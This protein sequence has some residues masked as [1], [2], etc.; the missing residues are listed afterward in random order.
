MS[1]RNFLTS[2]VFF[3]NLFLVLV[4]VILIIF[5]VMQWL[6]VYTHHGEANPV[7]DFSGMT[8]D[9]IAATAAQ[10]N[11]DYEIT[12]SVYDD[13]AQ[14]GAV[15][16]QQP[17]AGFKVKQNRK[18]FLTINSTQRERI[19]LPKL[20]NISFRQAQVLAENSGI[21]IGNIYYEPSEF[22]DLVLRVEQDS[23]PI[24]TGDMILK[25]SSIDLV[26][27]RSHGN[28]DTSLPDLTGITISDA[29][30]VLTNAM[31][32]MGVLIYDTTCKDAEDSLNAFVWR[33]Y[34][35]QKNTKK[36]GLGSSVDLW[37]TVDSIK[38]ASPEE[39]EEIE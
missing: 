23:L 7:P 29:K 33:Q 18:I 10:N 34:P 16:E 28:E 32:N 30:I 20:T 36:I 11:L 8:I 25:G 6:Q 2:R 24:N 3:I 39:L 5:F 26:L 9:E 21:T 38:I 22:N 19:A 37:L 31:L 12:D 4:I 17:E 14:P 13:S 1:L 27:G 15:V 35:S